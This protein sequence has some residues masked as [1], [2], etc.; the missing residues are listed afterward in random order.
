M[1]NNVHFISNTPEDK[2]CLQASYAMI[3]H[4]YE[5]GLQ[6]DWDEWADLTG[7]LPGKGTWS[8]AGLM[9]FKEHGYEVIHIATF[10]YREFAER[11]AEYLVESLGEEV[12]NWELKFMDLLLEQDRA[13]KFLDSGIWLKR[14]VTI[15]DIYTFLNQGYLIKCLMNLNALNG[16]PGYL[17]HAVVVK[18]YDENGLIL[19]DPGLPAR[20][21]RHVTVEAFKAAWGD[22]NSAHSEKMDVIRKVSPLRPAPEQNFNPVELAEAV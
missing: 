1:D 11:G 22:P 12:A 21:N 5:P 17:G 7:Y 8:M 3:R 16:K 13:V 2:Q 9:W 19:H 18:G 6:I 14:E 20:P 10:D 4:F 15:E